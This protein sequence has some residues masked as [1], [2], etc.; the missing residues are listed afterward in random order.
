MLALLGNLERWE[1]L[2]ETLLDRQVVQNRKPCF[3][4][5]ATSPVSS[6]LSRNLRFRKSVD[7]REDRNRARLTSQTLPL[8]LKDV[9]RAARGRLWNLPETFRSGQCYVVES[10]ET[11]FRDRIL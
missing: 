10:W 1:Y 11:G 8:S 3:G 4:N 7:V 2:V 6:V 9:P 5:L